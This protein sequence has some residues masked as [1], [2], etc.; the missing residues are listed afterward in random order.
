VNFTIQGKL[1]NLLAADSVP[2]VRHKI[3]FREGLETLII[4]RY[5]GGLLNN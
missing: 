2:Q 3:A 4:K 1:Q 5:Y